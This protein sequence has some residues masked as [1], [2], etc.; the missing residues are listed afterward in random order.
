MSAS[1]NDF[2]RLKRR[3]ALA[4]RTLGLGGG[5]P[6]DHP[7]ALRGV[8]ALSGPIAAGLLGDAAM[9]LVDAKLVGSLG[10]SALGGVGLGLTLMYLCY[11]TVF[12][13]M[14][15]VKVRTAFAAGRGAPEDGRRYALAG[16]WVGAALGVLV[17]ALGRDLGWAF[18]LLGTGAALREQ[19]VAF[20]AAVSWG[21]PA[22]FVMSALVQHRQGLGDARTPMV[23]GIAGN[24]VNAILAYALIHGRL[25]LPALGVRGAGLA[26]ALTQTLQAAAL[27]A[28]LLRSRESRASTLTLG[29]AL[30][31]VSSL[32]IPTG[33]HFAAEMLAFTTFTAILGSLGEVQIAAHQVALAVIRA[34]FLPGIAVGEAAS[35]LVGQALGRRNLAAADRATRA[36]LTLAV[37]FMAGCA[38]V[39]AIFGR[40][41]ASGFTTDPEVVRVA[42]QLLWI[43]AIFQVLDAVNIVLRGAL[44]G[45]KDV[46][47]VATLGITIVWTCVPTAAFVLGRLAG[48]GAVGGWCGF[49]VETLLASVLFSLRWRRGDWRRGYEHEPAPPPEPA[50]RD[51]AAGAVAPSS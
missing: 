34:S 45:A 51:I 19:G 22:V 44:R 11:S 12:G 14:R 17:F 38:L 24:I 13:L 3:V 50:Q 21:A 31:E 30:K 25:G 16:V 47:M 43:A 33:L 40:W 10:A 20:F 28:L 23:V 2:S 4:A 39:F 32:G 6:E 8:A 36:A 27:L 48:W 46:R 29:Q 35:V 41:I 1:E 42:T 5:R 49:V 18:D 37:A 26:T 15:G 9:G 7:S